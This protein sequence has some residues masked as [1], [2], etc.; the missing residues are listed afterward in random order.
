MCIADN[1]TLRF[2]IVAWENARNE[3]NAQIRWNF[4]TDEARRVFKQHYPTSL[5]LMYQIELNLIS[6]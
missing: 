6:I 5:R 2:G 4:T 3:R 1:R